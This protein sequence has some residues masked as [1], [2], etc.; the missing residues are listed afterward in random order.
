MDAL[1]RDASP[2]SRSSLYAHRFWLTLQGLPVAV[3]M[4]RVETLSTPGS[5]VVAWLVGSAQAL[6][7]VLI[8]RLVEKNEDDA[9]LNVKYRRNWL[10]FACLLGVTSVSVTLVLL[11]SMANVQT[12][13]LLNLIAAVFQILSVIAIRLWPLKEKFHA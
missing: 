10:G 8:L 6:I 1:G 13:V 5:S 4:F 3:A 12:V 11:L 2:G 9:F 7:W